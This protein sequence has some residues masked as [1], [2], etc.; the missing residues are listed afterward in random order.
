MNDRIYDTSSGDL[1]PQIVANAINV[2]ITIVTETRDEYYATE[3]VPCTRTASES[4][5][6][7]WKYDKH[8]DAIKPI[9]AHGDI[10]HN[11]E[12]VFADFP[13]CDMVDTRGKRVSNDTHVKILSMNICGLCEWKLADDVLGTH[14]KKFDIILFQET[15]SAAGDEFSLDGYVFFNFPRKYSHQLS[16][17]NS[18]GLGVFL[19]IG[20]SEGVKF[21]KHRDDIL[22][23]L[24]LDKNF[25]GLA[26]DLYVANVY[27]VPEISVYLCHDAFHI[28]QDDLGGFP[29]NSD[30]LVCGDYNARTNVVPNFIG[31]V[32]NGNNG[33]LPVINSASDS[34][35]ILIREMSENGKLERFSKDEARTNKHG[36]Q[37]I[38]LCKAVGLLIINGR[39][40]KD[41]GIGGFTRVD[42]T[43][44][45]TVDYMIC[46][47]ELLSIIYDFMIGPRFPESDHC[48]L[49]IQ[50][51]C[52]SHN[53]S[54]VDTSNSDWVSFKK[55]KWSNNDLL[56]LNYVL[57]DALSEKHCE[58]FLAALSELKRHQFRC[59]AVQ[60]VPSTSSGPC[61][62]GVDNCQ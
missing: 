23:W 37:L 40:G 16:I 41:K 21:I 15:W 60:C 49:S 13:P 25:F 45:S 31:E 54:D 11:S 47:P 57:N 28:L 22:V 14:F 12:S 24:K 58:Q 5:I 53:T 7:I 35:S 3:R 20:L 48:G 9:C 62:H 34:R 1:V 30:F 33:D 52:K 38:E 56:N 55:Y 50:I 2:N 27:I 44:R 29:T 43:D 42:T 4:E 10:I 19:K 8:Y 18:G 17:R 26:K 32:S 6:V 61:L 39:V 36:I 59:R 51:H 46:N